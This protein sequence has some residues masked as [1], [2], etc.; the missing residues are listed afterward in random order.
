MKEVRS[1]IKTASLTE[2]EKAQ[3]LINDAI[4]KYTRKGGGAKDTTFPIS[5]PCQKTMFP[6]F[7]EVGWSEVVPKSWD[8]TIWLSLITNPTLF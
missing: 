2:L 7:G 4:S 6:P 8:E 3:Q 1:F 5:V